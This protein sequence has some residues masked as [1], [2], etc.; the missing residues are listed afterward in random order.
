MKVRQLEEEREGEKRRAEH[1]DFGVYLL[2]L[3][4]RRIHQVDARTAVRP[5]D[6]LQRQT[7][8]GGLDTIGTGVVPSIKGATLGASRRVGAESSIPGIAYLKTKLEPS[9]DSYIS[10]F[11]DS[12]S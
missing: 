7:A 12:P 9:L 2:I 6:Q 3:R 11:M 4:V 5:R 1:F 8:A 10:R